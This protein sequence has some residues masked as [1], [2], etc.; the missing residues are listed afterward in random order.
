MSYKTEAVTELAKQIKAAGFRVF[1]AK[2]GTY[3]FYTDEAGE[4]LVSFQFDLGG[5][6]FTGNYKTD[7]PHGCGTGWQLVEG[8]SFQEM[9]NE[10]PTWSLRGAKWH[11]TTVEQYLSTYQRSSVFTE[12]QAADYVH[13]GMT[14]AQARRKTG[15]QG[16]FEGPLPLCG[17]GSFHAGVT[18]DVESVTCIFC[19]ATLKSRPN[20]L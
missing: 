20:Y 7:N 16:S 1:I 10:C 4:K 19:K 14:E 13:Y 15:T 17:N 3:G 5:F 2:S 6:R 18:S 8:R 12:F 9:F 11:Y